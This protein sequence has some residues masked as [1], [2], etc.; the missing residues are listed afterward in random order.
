MRTRDHLEALLPA[1]KPLSWFRAGRQI[2]VA[3]KMQTRYCYTLQEAP[4]K[5][6]GFRPALTP[7]QMLRRGV[8]EGKYL[9]DCV[10]EF[11]REWFAEALAKLSPGRADPALNEFGVKSRKP[12][13]YWRDKGWVPIVPG[14]P[15]VRGWFQWYCRYWLGRRVPGLD[16]VQIKRWGSFKRHASQILAS[17]KKT[18]APPTTRAEKKVHRPRQRQA[19]LQWA[20]DPYV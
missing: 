19:L 18:R 12:L 1:A 9:N 16:E 4:G 7:A 13:K 15:D 3:D 8:F 17:Y 2:H 5:N 10:L 20:W 14:D 6:L 11:P